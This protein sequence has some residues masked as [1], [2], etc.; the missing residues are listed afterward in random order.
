MTAAGS[1]YFLTII[2]VFSQNLVQNG[3]FEEDGGSFAGWTI[4][5]PNGDTNYAN[6]SPTIATGGDDDPYYARFEYEQSGA[7]DLLSQEI[8]TIPGDLYDISFD[9]EDGGGHNFQTA[10]SFGAATEDLGPAFAIGPGEWYEGWTNFSFDLMAAEVETELSFL[11]W[12]DIGSEFGVDDISVTP[13]P[14]LSETV[15]EGKFQVTVTNCCA[16]VVI[17]V[18][19]NMIDWVNVCTNTAPCTFT[20]SCAAHPKCFFRAAVLQQTGQP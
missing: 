20:D 7:G 12:A 15:T 11:I 19:T 3:N 2:S 6:D 9:A 16:S 10:F 17:Q 4:S 5:H 1:V 8:A 14:Q 18:S 13:V